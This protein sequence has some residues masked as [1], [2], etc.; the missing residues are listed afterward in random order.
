M[1]SYES[2]LNFISGKGDSKCVA[3]WVF[4]STFWIKRCSTIFYKICYIGIYVRVQYMQ[5]VIRV[6]EY[7]ILRNK[8]VLYIECTF[9]HTIPARSWLFHLLNTKGHQFRLSLYTALYLFSNRVSIFSL[10][11]QRLMV[12]IVPCH[13]WIDLFL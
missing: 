10:S 5:V 13:Q 4:S 12:G 2:K 8:A 6:N 1:F 3:F 11:S 9:E 7:D